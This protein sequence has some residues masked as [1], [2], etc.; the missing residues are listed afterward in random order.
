LNTRLQADPKNIAI[1]LILASLYLEQ[2][3]YDDA[4][5]EYTSV[6]AEHPADAVALNNLAWLYQ[7]K[8]DLAKARGL[9]EQ[10]VAAAPRTTQIADTLG[11]IF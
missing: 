11:W 2:K 1:R 9:A 3:K 6:L 10:A 4:I 8:G 5:A 7:Q